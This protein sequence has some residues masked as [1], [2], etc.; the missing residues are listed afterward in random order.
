MKKKLL[1][2]TDVTTFKAAYKSLPKDDVDIV[3]YDKAKEAGLA[4]HTMA[5]LELII[6]TK[7]V[8][9]DENKNSFS[10][11]FDNISQQKWAPWF[12]GGHSG[13][14]F[15]DSGYAHAGSVPLLGSRLCLSDEKRSDFMGKTFTSIYKRFIIK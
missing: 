15:L 13:F 3:N 6:I 8:N 5:E 12:S 7:V 11:D 9:T 2:Y 14:R 4:D 10:P 1:N